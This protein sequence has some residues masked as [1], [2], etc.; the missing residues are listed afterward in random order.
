MK[1]VHESIE[2]YELRFFSLFNCQANKLWRVF[3]KLQ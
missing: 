1:A 2:T 3:E